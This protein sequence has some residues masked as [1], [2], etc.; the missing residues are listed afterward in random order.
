VAPESVRT[1]ALDFVSVSILNGIHVTHVDGDDVGH[2]EKGCHAGTYLGGEAGIL[3][4]IGLVK[5][6]LNRIVE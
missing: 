6:V 3:D 1:D 2:S 4:F 5:S